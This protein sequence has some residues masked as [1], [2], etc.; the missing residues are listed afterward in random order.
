MTTFITTQTSFTNANSVSA[1]WLARAAVSVRN[2][3]KEASRRRAERDLFDMVQHCEA[4]QP[5]LAAELRAA[6]CHSD[7]DTSRA[8]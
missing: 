2:A 5:M 1:G 8:L 6:Y 4:S 3:L 7:R